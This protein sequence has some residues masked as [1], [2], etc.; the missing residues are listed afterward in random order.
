M[1]QERP[2]GDPPSQHVQNLKEF[3]VVLNSR[4]CDQIKM[5]LEK[6][7]EWKVLDK[8]I[9]D[10]EED[11]VTVEEELIVK[12]PK[13]NEVGIENLTEE[14][15]DQS[16]GAGVI[17]PSANSEYREITIIDPT[18]FKHKELV[19]HLKYSCLEEDSLLLVITKSDSWD[20]DG[21]LTV[22]QY[23]KMKNDNPKGIERFNP[24][25]F[26]RKSSEDT[27]TCSLSFLHVIC[28]VIHSRQPP[29]ETRIL[30]LLLEITPNLA[31]RATGTPLN[32]VKETMWYLFDLTPSVVVKND[33]Q[34]HGLRPRIANQHLKGF[35]K[36]V[37]S[38]DLDGAN[39]ERMRLRLFQFSLRDQASNWL[40]RLPAESIST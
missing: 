2:Q 29:W 16:V 22:L 31:T 33:S 34:I 11:E 26:Q 18:V 23:H 12:K 25:I 32:F 28:F 38:L 39:R 8:N 35:L 24:L 37:D 20:K 30:S 3:K 21:L 5:N 6:E 19:S 10:N 17:R 1:L 40:E 4:E 14:V 7:N 27:L 13:V 36:L 15:I 9:V